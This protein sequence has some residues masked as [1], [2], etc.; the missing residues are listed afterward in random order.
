MP[1]LLEKNKKSVKKK[2]WSAERKFY[3]SFKPEDYDKMIALENQFDREI[4]GRDPILER[5]RHMAKAYEAQERSA[6]EFWGQISDAEE[7]GEDGIYPESW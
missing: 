2:L 4:L 7:T 6:A 3:K 1:Q 5:D